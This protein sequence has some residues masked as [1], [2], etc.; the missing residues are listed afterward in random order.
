MAYRIRA[1]LRPVYDVP[2]F[3]CWAGA[4]N[5][6]LRWCWADLAG[7]LWFASSASSSLVVGPLSSLNFFT[8]V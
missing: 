5:F 2:F 1:L 6:C 4:K 3:P 7:S 8:D